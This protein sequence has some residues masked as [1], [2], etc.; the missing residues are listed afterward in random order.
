MLFNLTFILTGFIQIYAYFI[1]LQGFLKKPKKSIAKVALAF[2]GLYLIMTVPY[3]LW[4]IPIVT[5]L[6]TFVGILSVTLIY[7]G[8]WQRRI[9]SGI[10]TLGIIVLSEFAVSIVSGYIGLDVFQS[11][12]YYSMFGTVCLPIVQLMIALFIR[13]FMN[14]KE[15]EDVSVSYWIIS[16]LLPLITIYL[17]LVFYKQPYLETKDILS[18][19]IVLFVINLFVFFLYD[20][21]MQ[22]FATQKEKETLELQNKYQLNEIQMMKEL[23]DKL[24]S[25]R[26][27]FIKHMS[28]ISYLNS[29]GEQ[30]QIDEYL[31][32]IQNNANSKQIFV[33]TGNLVFDSI[34]NYKIQEMMS[35]DIKVEFEVVVPEDLEV[36]IYDMN[37][38]LTNLLDNSMEAV[39]GLDTKVVRLKIIYNH[40]KLN[41]EIENKYKGKRNSNK[42]GY[43]TTKADVKNH[44]YGLRN[45]EII[46]E[47][48]DGVM[49][50]NDENNVFYVFIC[51]FL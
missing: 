27:D 3:L 40:N 2:I 42:E 37:I 9:L 23:V 47:K 4:H 1:L 7:E 31:T 28:M 36:S 6:C 43:F 50:I 26:H 10:F 30:K 33:N 17:F 45:I 46:V 49:K 19:V 48:Y 44:G 20:K 11:E 32:E 22:S 38:I 25:L 14:M 8:S 29:Q 34:L 51:L 24:R 16:A 15:G 35:K 5:F 18:C 39:S 12:E 13:N 41:I 21:Q